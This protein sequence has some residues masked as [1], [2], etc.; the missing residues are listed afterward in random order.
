MQD[1]DIKE[2]T[3]HDDNYWRIDWFG[4]LSYYD[5]NG[6]RRSV[7]LIDIFVSKLKSSPWKSNLYYKSASDYEHQRK[8]SIPIGYLPIFRLGDVWQRGKH[9]ITPKYEVLNT[10]QI[11]ISPE[12][13]KTHLTSD[14]INGNYLVPYTWH[15]YHKKAPRT[16]CEVITQPDGR[17]IVIPHWVILQTYFGCCSF[18]FTQLFQ[19]GVK[20]STLYDP[21]STYLVD[22]HGVLQVKK[23]VHDVA[24]PDVARIA[25][26]QTT[27][28]A[29]KMAS[30]S[31]SLANSNNQPVT[32]KT[33]FPFSGKTSLQLHGKFVPNSGYP[34][35]FIV[36]NILS[37]TAD[38]PFKSLEFY[39]DNPGNTEDSPSKTRPNQNQGSRVP[40]HIPKAKEQLHLTPGQ[41]P[42][43]QLEEL[44]L[45]APQR[46]SLLSLESKSIEKKYKKPISPTAPQPGITSEPV[47]TGNVGTGIHEGEGAPVMFTVDNDSIKKPPFCFDHQFCRLL[48][49]RKVCNHLSKKDR[50]KSIRFIP[51]NSSFGPSEGIYSFFPKT[52]TPSRRERMWR[53]VGY[54]KGNENKDYTKRKALIAEIITDTHI[55]YVLDIERRTALTENNKAWI[56]LDNTAMLLLYSQ[57]APL[58]NESDFQGLLERCAERSG[59]WSNGEDGTEDLSMYAGY[60]SKVIKHPANSTTS[61]IN[62]HINCLVKD[63]ES[64]T[65]IKFEE[66]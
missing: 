17:L 26:D 20:L 60:L 10:G 61:D 48:T 64:A 7:P 29:Y 22:G 16:Q 33:K 32:P 39:R 5:E 45:S 3:N 56:E 40:R 1:F 35:T 46:T 8:V 38:F 59:R 47:S 66:I 44:M 27:K 13:T 21:A 6:E 11:Y 9:V 52:F 18:V 53:Y 31:L 24:V 36:F 37:C 63:I 14:K 58:L 43:S 49:L 25:W 28:K 57:S 2:L 30:E 54:I 19:F 50:V 42:K 65:E 41:E 51:V 55:L 23:W 4:Y 62:T 34:D 12:T 15:P